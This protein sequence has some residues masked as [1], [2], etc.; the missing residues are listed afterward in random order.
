MSLDTER[1]G[2]ARGVILGEAHSQRTW[3]VVKLQELRSNGRGQL[4]T[5]AMRDDSGAGQGSLTG[6]GA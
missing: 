1:T 2:N 3:F 5:G 4:E 6:R